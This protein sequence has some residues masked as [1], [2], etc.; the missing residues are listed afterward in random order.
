MAR[1]PDSDAE[2]DDTL[3]QKFP[4]TVLETM[5]VLER[6]Q[7]RDHVLQPMSLLLT[8][9]TQQNSRQSCI[10]LPKTVKLL[11]CSITCFAIVHDWEPDKGRH[12][13]YKACQTR[14]LA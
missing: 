6:N 4:G 1:L 7:V 9:V 5:Q 11:R 2:T 10:F 13:L 14:L 8:Q 12:G 3:K